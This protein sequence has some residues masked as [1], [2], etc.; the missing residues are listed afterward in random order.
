MR[1]LECFLFTLFLGMC[2]GVRACVRVCVCVRY[3][4]SFLFKAFTLMRSHWWVL[5]NRNGTVTSRFW[6]PPTP[7]PHAA[8]VKCPHWRVLTE[9]C[10]R[11]QEACLGWGATG[12][13]HILVLSTIASLTHALRCT[14]SGGKQG[15]KRAT[16]FRESS[17]SSPTVI[18]PI[19]AWRCWWGRPCWWRTKCLPVACLWVCLGLRLGSRHAQILA[20]IEPFSSENDFKVPST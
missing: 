8:L 1:S 7:C 13:S 19:R 11:A 14:W 2:I 10:W 20:Q 4:T 16:D 3:A 17:R 6:L 15:A 18:S 5:C 9:K 12:H